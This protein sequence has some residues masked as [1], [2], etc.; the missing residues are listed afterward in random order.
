MSTITTQMI[1]DIIDTHNEQKDLAPADVADL[2]SVPYQ[3]VIKVLNGYEALVHLSAEDVEFLKKNKPN[4]PLYNAI[5]ELYG[6][7]SPFGKKPAQKKE[8]EPELKEE[9]PKRDIL[10]E[11]RKKRDY[12]KTRYWVLN[13]LLEEL[14][15]NG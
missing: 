3:T 2:L 8:P 5:I 11:I 6:L 1:K 9:T 7:E 14:E 12:Y 13:E 10:E 4:R 15:K